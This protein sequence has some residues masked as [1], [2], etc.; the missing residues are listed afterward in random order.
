MHLLEG[1]V[2]RGRYS[3]YHMSCPRELYLYSREIWLERVGVPEL[4][5]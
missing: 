1:V 5:S 2:C 3:D 4:P